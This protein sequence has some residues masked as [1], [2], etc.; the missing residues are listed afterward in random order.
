[1]EPFEEI[2]D[3]AAVGFSRGPGLALVCSQ[4]SITV[5]S[6]VPIGTAAGDL[7]IV[8]EDFSCNIVK[9]W[10]FSVKHNYITWRILPVNLRPQI[11]LRCVDA[12][13]PERELDLLDVSAVRPGELSKGSAKV[14]RR[15]LLFG[16]VTVAL[17]DAIDALGG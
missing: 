5:S 9:L 13:V 8:S 17:G 1:I 11:S 14:V 6:S 15:D 2:G 3:V 7:M 4:S 10:Y 12:L 16:H